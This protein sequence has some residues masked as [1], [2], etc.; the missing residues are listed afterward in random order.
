[1]SV[2]TIRLFAGSPGLRQMAGSSAASALAVATATVSPFAW[3]VAVAIG[4]GGGG[5]PA[6]ER[7]RRRQALHQKFTRMPPV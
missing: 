5:R 4:A 6:G 3:T 2:A 7:G 1:L